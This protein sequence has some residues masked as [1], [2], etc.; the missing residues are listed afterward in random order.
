MS[1]KK[2][3]SAAKPFRRW[4]VLLRAFG[5]AAA[6][7]PP[8]EAIR[9]GLGALVGLALVGLLTLTPWVD[10]TLGFYLIAPFAASSVLLFA[11]P[12]SPLAQPWPAVVGNVIAAVVGVAVCLLVTEP[13]LRVAVAV[14]LAITFMSLCRAVHPPA[15]AVAMTAALNPDMMAE[16]GFFF[17]LVPVA[18]GSVVLVVIAMVYA[19]ATG[20]HYP[21]RQF[22][23]P[24][25]HGTA[26]PDPVARLGLSEAELSEILE[27]YRQTLNLGIEDL[28]RLIGAAE[29]RAAGHRTGPLTVSDIMSRQLVTV[30]PDT[31]LGE[32][33]DLF[34]Q[35]RFT[36]LPVVE[37][38]NRFLGV[39]FQSHL[40]DRARD[41]ALRLERGFAAAMARLLDND[42]D[43]PARARDIMGVA[44]PRVTQHAPIAAVVPMMAASDC[45]AVPVLD[46][47]RIIGIVTRTDLVAA[48]A[49]ESLTR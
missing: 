45:D 34:R 41:D 1:D 48:L 21:L 25:D 49:R 22:D 38:E 43:G 20:R 3:D 4:P 30:A 46:H 23:G 12:N 11:V 27:Q 35:H 40:I 17:A 6:G 5:P 29:V 37:A 39:I 2:T 14:G 10:K 28:A 18:F 15:G 44:G 33:A 31:R 8:A 9:A 24:K 47:G 36:V 13:V 16:Q 19:R 7:A 26:E 42:R 32:I